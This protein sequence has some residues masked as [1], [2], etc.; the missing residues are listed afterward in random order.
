MIKRSVGFCS[1]CTQ[2]ILMEHRTPKRSVHESV[3]LWEDHGICSDILWPR[4]PTW[5][6]S[7][8]FWNRHIVVS[9]D[10]DILRGAVMFQSV[11]TAYGAVFVSNTKE[12]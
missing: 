9:E 10:S 8:N 4:N 11:A 7:V 1:Y 6:S 3:Y 12:S 2:N 5:L